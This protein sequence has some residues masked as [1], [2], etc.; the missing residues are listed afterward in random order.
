MK[1]GR[2]AVITPYF[3]ETPEVLKRCVDSVKQQSIKADHFLVADGCPQD[4][5]DRA[6]VRHLRLDT[7]H[8][9]CGN[10]PRGIGALLAISEGYKG[11]G[12]LDADNWYDC[13]HVEQCCAVE[14]SIEGVPADLVAAQRRILLADGTPTNLPEYADHVDTSC[15][16]L[17]EGAFSVAHYWLTMPRQVAPLCDRIF[18]RVVTANCLTMCHTNSV[19]VNFISNHARFY[20]T[21]GKAPPS[22]AKTIDRISIINW[23]KSLDGRQQRLASLRCGIDLVALLPDLSAVRL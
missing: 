21:V 4:W 1:D 15:Y 12:F 6:G 14:S 11:I 20:S 10:T 22:D 7:A 3:K 13:D 18:Y 23:I 17:L 19:T 9:D 5:V 2:F 8:K 16:W